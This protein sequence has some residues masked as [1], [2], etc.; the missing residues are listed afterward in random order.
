MFLKSPSRGTFICILSPFLYKQIRI[1]N[2]VVTPAIM[3]GGLGVIPFN[4]Q[5]F[6]VFL[7]SV[8]QRLRGTVN[9]GYSQRFLN[10]LGFTSCRLLYRSPA[11][12]SLQKSSTVEL[13]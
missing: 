4:V 10:I 11:I 1:F 9:S 12:D 7:A 3:M 6:P 5:V 8:S 13:F 2:Q